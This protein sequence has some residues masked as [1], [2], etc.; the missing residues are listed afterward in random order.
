MKRKLGII[1]SICFLFTGIFVQ[2]PIPQV[3]AA[4]QTTFYVSPSGNDSNSGTQSAPFKT[5]EKAR[6]TVRTINSSMTGDI[7]VYLMD[8]TYA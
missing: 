4:A 6:D 3:M 1:T 5:I 2:G 7:Y 8:G